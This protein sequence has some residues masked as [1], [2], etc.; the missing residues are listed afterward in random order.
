MHRKL[1]VVGILIVFSMLNGCATY[2][3]TLTDA[4]GHQVT[5]EASGKSGLLTGYYL[6]SGFDNC[7]SNAESHGFAAAPVATIP[8]SAVQPA[9]PS[10]Y[11]CTPKN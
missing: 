4:Q 10:G 2:K 1:M 6:R 7:V 9:C 5:C 11:T 3:T 8:A